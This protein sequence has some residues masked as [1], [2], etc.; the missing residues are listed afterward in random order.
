MGNFVIGNSGVVG[1]MIAILIINGSDL[2]A[3]LWVGC[4]LLFVATFLLT[5][6]FIESGDEQL[7]LEL[8]NIEGY[9]L[10]VR[11]VMDRYCQAE[12]N[13]PRYDLMA[14]MGTGVRPQFYS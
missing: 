3:P 13:R 10:R 2:F 4:R 1:G 9:T 7:A 8:K 6:Y 5:F 14:V 11:Q 12:E